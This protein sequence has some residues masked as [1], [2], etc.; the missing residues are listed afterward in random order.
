MKTL[1]SILFLF[2]AFTSNGQDE[3]RLKY[4]EETNHVFYQGIIQNTDLDSVRAR[5]IGKEW[6]EGT[7]QKI[8]LSKEEEN[9][10]F[11]IVSFNTTGKSSVYGKTYYYIFTAEICIEFKNGKTRYTLNNFKKKSSPGEPGSTLEYFIENFK[12][13]ISSKKSR[14]REAQ[15]LDEI[16]IELDSQIGDLV[17]ELKDTFGSSKKEDW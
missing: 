11:G 2:V 1:F 12:P 4:N 6:L 16:E 7:K 14:D 15:L 5:Q 8:V 17:V 9:K 10:L 3:Y 13:K